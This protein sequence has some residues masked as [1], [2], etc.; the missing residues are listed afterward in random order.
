MPNGDRLVT[1]D[2]WGKI[3][4]WRNRANVFAC[5]CQMTTAVHVTDIQW[6]RCG[7]YII[8]CGKDGHIQMFSGLSGLNLF[9]ITVQATTSLTSKAQSTCCSW[10]KTGTRIAF[11]TEA[12][13]ILLLDPAENGSSIS[14]M[15]L[16]QGVAV[17][18][19]LWYGAVRT[20]QTR[21]GKSYQSQ[22]LSVLLRTGQVVCFKDT[23]SS[24]CMWTQTG[25]YDG[26]AAWDSCYS[27]LAVVGYTKEE[28]T[29]AVRFMNRKG[30]VLFTINDALPQIP[31][32]Q[33]GGLLLNMH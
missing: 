20:C 31:R 33:V 28:N 19:I 8:V 4:V 23:S 24:H 27:L 1:Y 14:T 2:S 25:I 5:E 6:S 22:S 9:S 12:G 17:C 18:S 11:G 15:T 10:N 29:C 3:I 30:Y 21:G 26:M 32:R 7:Y 13:E 16:K